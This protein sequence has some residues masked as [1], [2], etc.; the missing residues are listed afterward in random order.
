MVGKP[1]TQVGKGLGVGRGLD[2]GRGIGMMNA[3][4]DAPARKFRYAPMKQQ[5]KKSQRAYVVVPDFAG[6]LYPCATF[7]LYGWVRV[8]SDVE[9]SDMKRSFLASPRN[10]YETSKNYVEL[11]VNG[12]TPL[13][14]HP[15]PPK[16][17]FTVNAVLKKNGRIIGEREVHQHRN[18]LDYLHNKTT[19][20]IGEVYFPLP[21]PT[22]TTPLSLSITGSYT[23]DFSPT[24]ATPISYGI[25]KQAQV[26][27]DFF[28]EATE[29]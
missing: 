1:E 9:F 28:I 11:G 5:F 22:D 29:E 27:I 10:N 8:I 26:E 13:L 16:I 12:T 25:P 3:D 21:E 24:S 2:V 14:Y 7:E 17:L 19:I 20:V 4:G 15:T 23:A 18:E 6:P